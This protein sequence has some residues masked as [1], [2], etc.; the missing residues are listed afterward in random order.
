MEFLTLL[1]VMLVLQ[2][3]D[4]NT[5]LQTDNWF[6]N[7][8]YYLRRHRFLSNSMLANSVLVAGFP[9][10]LLALCVLLTMDLV[11]GF[12]L[13]LLYCVSLFYSMGRGNFTEDLKTYKAAWA[14]SDIQ[15]AFTLIDHFRHSDSYNPQNLKDLHTMARSLILYRAFE[16]FFVV[17][18]FFAMLGPAAALFYRLMFLY[19][20]RLLDRHSQ[21][22][23][24]LKVFLQL[25]E[26]LPARLMGFCFCLL[27]SFKPGFDAWLKTLGG[28]GLNSQDYLNHIAE[29]TLAWEEGCAEQA[30]PQSQSE[31]QLF[32][33]TACEEITVIQALLRHSAILV[34]AVLA[35]LASINL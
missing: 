11:F 7:W 13:L 24:D 10:V 26:W 12:V 35:L 14:R 6:F 31:Q 23:A 4:G 30:E 34:L 1:I 16:R 32:M 27:G 5:P 17:I 8:V 19:C 18:F 9:A 3:R 21:E 25:L 15:G 28:Q 33:Q 22:Y 20:H 29:K 2:W